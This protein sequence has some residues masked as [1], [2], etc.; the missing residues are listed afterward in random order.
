MGQLT[1]A[2]ILARKYGRDVVDLGDGETVTV[3]GLSRNE[4][5]R[6][7]AAEKTV[8]RDVSPKVKQDAV[9]ISIGLVD[10]VLSVDEVI[11]WFDDA[12]AGDIKAIAQRIAE[13]SGMGEGQ[14]KQATKSVPRRRGRR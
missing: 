3:R 11:D 5:D 6:V 12:P 1:K 13:L 8:E 10:P 7:A 4:A 14:G 2:Q 9:M